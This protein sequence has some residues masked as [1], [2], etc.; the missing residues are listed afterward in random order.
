MK[1]III[2]AACIAAGVV[3]ENKFGV[4]DKAIEKSKKLFD[5][6]VKKAKKLKEDVE[7]NI[8]EIKEEVA[9]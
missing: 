2:A 1:K 9:E 6:I 5:Y 4:Q 7:E 3:L 8:D